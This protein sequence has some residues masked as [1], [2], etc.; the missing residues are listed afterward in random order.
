MMERDEDARIL[1]GKLRC[2]VEEKDE[3]LCRVI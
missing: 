1:L 2:K 3:S